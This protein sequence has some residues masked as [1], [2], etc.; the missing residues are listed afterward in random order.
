MWW[1][2]TLILQ[3]NLS[4]ILIL[5]K[6]PFNPL[7]LTTVKVDRKITIN[8]ELDFAE[9]VQGTPIQGIFKTVVC[10]HGTSVIIGHYTTNIVNSES[11]INVSDNNIS[12]GTKMIL[13][14]FLW[15]TSFFGSGC[16][17]IVEMLGCNISNDSW[18][19]LA[20][21]DTYI[22]NILKNGIINK[23]ATLLKSSLVNCTWN[24]SV[25]I[26][27]AIFQHIF[28]YIKDAH[29]QSN[30]KNVLFLKV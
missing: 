10:N 14:P 3:Q 22:P 15:L 11:R 20:N 30:A 17:T 13:R 5:N 21:A 2:V 8:R 27:K 7:T 19:F 16:Q 6:F 12:I 25:E 1:I 9:F 26:P 23:A 4:K 29:L 24:N 28:G 18:F